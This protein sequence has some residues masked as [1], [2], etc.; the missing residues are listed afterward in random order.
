MLATVPVVS[1]LGV[2]EP[3]LWIPEFGI[4]SIQIL[5]VPTVQQVW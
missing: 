4:W 1:G 3:R 5:V 2:R